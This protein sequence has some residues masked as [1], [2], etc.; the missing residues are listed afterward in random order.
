[1]SKRSSGESPTSKGK[2]RKSA[3]GNNKV[4]NKGDSG[5]SNYLARIDSDSLGSY[6]EIDSSNAGRHSRTSRR[7]LSASSTTAKALSGGR[8]SRGSRSSAGNVKIN[9]PKTPKADK[10]RS[11]TPVLESEEDEANITANQSTITK[12]SQ[13]T[14]T[15][16]SSSSS[17]RRKSSSKLQTVPA[18]EQQ[19]LVKAKA[20]PKPKQPKSKKQGK[21]SFGIPPTPSELPIDKDIQEALLDSPQQKELGVGKYDYQPR[22]K[23][24]DYKQENSDRYLTKAGV[25]SSDEDFDED[26]DDDDDD[27]TG[28]ATDQAVVELLTDDDYEDEDEDEDISATVG[29]AAPPPAWPSFTDALKSAQQASTTTNTTTSMVV[30][31]GDKES[32]QPRQ[33]SSIN[34]IATTADKRKPLNKYNFSM[35]PSTSVNNV[36]SNLQSSYSMNGVNDSSNA[37]KNADFAV[38]QAGSSTIDNNSMDLLHRLNTRFMEAVRGTGPAL[39]TYEHKLMMDLLNTGSRSLQVPQSPPKRFPAPTRATLTTSTSSSSQLVKR[40]LDVYEGAYTQQHQYNQ[41]Q[42]MQHRP[43][44]KRRKSLNAWGH[45]VS[46]PSYGNS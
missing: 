41:Q 32:Q 46:T 15:P 9:V 24:E 42:Q 17:S 33:F 25:D 34:H 45:V 2:G 21:Q 11:P 38:S 26:D 19:P 10:E 31:K 36:N 12:L 8:K 44:A 37:D 5:T 20:Q 4:D 30:R 39:S 3:G 7:S 27:G 40:P 13:A 35:M 14:S 43:D 1:M 23:K 6:W 29:I 28:L 22:D 18:L 16:P